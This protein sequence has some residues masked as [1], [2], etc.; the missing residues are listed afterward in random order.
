M[1]DRQVRF[2]TL[3]PFAFSEALLKKD[4]TV[5]NYGLVDDRFCVYLHKDSDGVVRYVGEGTLTRAYAKTRTDQ[6]HW[7]ALFKDNPPVVEI[8]KDCITKSEAEDLEI[9]L[10]KVHQSTIINNPHAT[11]KVHVIDYDDIS[12]FLYYDESSSTMLRWK[13]HMKNNS[14]A[15]SEAGHIRKDGRYA[16]VELKGRNLSVHRVVWVLHNRCLDIKHMI[17]HIDGNKSNNRISNL[18]VSDAKL[19]C[20]NL[21]MTIPT[22][23]YR[24]IKEYIIDGKVVSYFIRWHSTDS[25]K[26]QC[27]SFSARTYGGL[28]EA[29]LA[30]YLFRESLIKAGYI[31][32]RAREGEVPLLNSE[33]KLVKEINEE[34]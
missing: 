8:V 1:A 30:T 14:V 15:N 19:N 16:H 31:S 5:N 6:P 18:R 29:L 11:K 3:L 33:I 9:V 12:S 27:K 22:S 21:I 24:N 10:R 23:G 7:G 28:K 4:K 20:R 2:F 25:T 34:C 32:E 26:R 17:D 13:N